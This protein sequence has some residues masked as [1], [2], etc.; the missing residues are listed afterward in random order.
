MIHAVFGALTDGHDQLHTLALEWP[1]LDFRDIHIGETAVL[2]K[3]LDGRAVFFDLRRLESSAL[4]EEGQKIERF[5][6]HDLPEIT[7][8]DRVV[9]DEN[10]F[11]D[12][13]LRPFGDG[14]N[15]A[16][17]VLA[18][19]VLDFVLHIDIGVVAVVVELENLLAVHLDALLVHNIAGFHFQ[20]PAH[21]AERN[22]LRTLDDDFLHNRPTL[23]KHSHTNA[24][25]KRFR[26][27]THIR[28]ATGLI[29]G[30]NILLGGALAVGLAN[31]RGKVRQY[32][33]FRNT[34]RSD[35]FH[36]DVINDWAG[37]FSRGLGVRGKDRKAEQSE[38]QRKREKER[39]AWFF[40]GEWVALRWGDKASVGIIQCPKVG[41]DT[42]VL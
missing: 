23:K 28:D 38:N 31:F 14:E 19:D 37:L 13:E 27:Q 1:C 18:G 40:H 11:F 4:V 32:A 26:E 24:V 29:Q 35:R 36:C 22:L 12:D 21:A 41:Q 3:G 16:R 8:E 6:L 17:A 25:S 30:P 15:Q 10:D 39:A 9:A 5:C 7:G 34:R 42:P 33:V 20:I 2:I